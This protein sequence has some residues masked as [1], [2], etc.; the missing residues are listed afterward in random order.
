MVEG[1]ISVAEVFFQ[2]GALRVFPASRMPHYLRHDHREE[3]ARKFRQGIRGPADLTLS[4]A[5]PQGGNAIGRH[6]RRSVVS[7]KFS[8]H[9]FSNLF[10]ADASLFPAGCFVNPQMT[11]MALAMLAADRVVGSA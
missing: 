1:V 3:D 7:P 2:A 8:L 9:D 4:T 11:A 10:V 6:I 5:H